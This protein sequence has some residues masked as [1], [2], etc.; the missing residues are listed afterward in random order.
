MVRN[1][2]CSFVLILGLAAHAAGQDDPVITAVKHFETSYATRIGLAVYDTE[3]NTSRHY[4]G[5]VRF[6]LNSTFKTLACAAVL[7]QIDQGEIGRDDLLTFTGADIVTY[8]PALEPLVSS[9]SISVSDTCHAAM[10]L[11]D[12]T[13]AN[14]ILEKLGGPEGLTRFLR[15]IGDTITRL[16]RYETSMNEGKPGDTRDTT[17]PLA[18]VSTL[19][20]IL[21]GTVLSD[22][23]KQ[24]LLD[25][26]MDNQ[27]AGPLLRSVMPT[28]WRIADRTGAGGYGSR[29]ITALVYPP[30]RKPIFIA[31]YLTE[32][33]LPISDRNHII[34]E[35]GRVLFKDLPQ[36]P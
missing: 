28:G 7:Q 6:P 34:A 27:V 10:T 30:E 21:T 24:Q 19:H 1:F 33:D 25:W 26:M 35:I 9:G 15:T 5:D 18:M 29:S 22:G 32:N 11:S 2:V 36:L 23:S 16:D 13:A 12:N 4:N 17:T 14:L 31:I 20:K 8:S 3:T